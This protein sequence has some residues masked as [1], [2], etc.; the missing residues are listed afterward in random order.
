MRLVTPFVE[1]AVEDVSDDNGYQK[2]YHL[3]VIE[4]GQIEYTVLTLETRKLSNPSAQK[5]GIE[6]VR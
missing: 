6:D 5:E 4:L 3:L 2:I 1:K